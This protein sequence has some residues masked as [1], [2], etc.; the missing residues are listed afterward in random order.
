MLIVSITKMMFFNEFYNKIEVCVWKNETR[1]TSIDPVSFIYEEN[2]NSALE[3]KDTDNKAYR[4]EK[5]IKMQKRR[6]R[7]RIRMA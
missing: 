6:M 4:R 5:P 2:N 7:I 1:G 3:D